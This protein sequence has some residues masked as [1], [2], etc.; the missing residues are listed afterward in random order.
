M[1]FDDFKREIKHY[2][3]MADITTGVKFWVDKDKKM[4]VCDIKSEGGYR[5]TAN[6]ISDVIT[7]LSRGRKFAFKPVYV[8]FFE[9]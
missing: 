7:V 8:R 5:L 3:V 2:L 6:S 9:E 1:T 4:F